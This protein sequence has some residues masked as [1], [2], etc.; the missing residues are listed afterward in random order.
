MDE[1]RPEGFRMD[2]KIHLLTWCCLNRFSPSIFSTQL[3]PL[4]PASTSL[5]YDTIETIEAGYVEEGWKADDYPAEPCPCPKI[6]LHGCQVP[7]L[8]HH[9]H[10]LLARTNRRHLRR[11]LDRSLPTN[12]RKGTS[13]RGLLFLQKVDPDLLQSILSV[14][15]RP[16]GFVRSLHCVHHESLD[17]WEPGWLSLLIC[18]YLHL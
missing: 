3:L 7:R 9:H 6:L 11:L 1:M 2:S 8:L 14:R 16:F 4:R 5:R 15:F 13:H 17:G 10:R 12:R 18:A